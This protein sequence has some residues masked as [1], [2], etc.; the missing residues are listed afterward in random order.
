MTTATIN[1]KHGT[2]YSKVWGALNSD[3][4]GVLDDE[5]NID[6]GC[7]VRHLLGS[8]WIYVDDVDGYDI[9]TDHDIAGMRIVAE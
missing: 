9:L 2:D 6:A 4:F 5:G 3:I 1:K 8:H 7:R